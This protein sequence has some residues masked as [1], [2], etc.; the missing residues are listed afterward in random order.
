MSVKE[1]LEKI[2]TA[3]DNVATPPDIVIEG[4]ELAQMK[5]ADGETVI[6]AESFEAGQPVVVVS[7]SGNVPLPVGD[8]VLEDGMILV[9]AEEGV[10]AEIKEAEVEEEVEAETEFVTTETFNAFKAEIEGLLTNMGKDPTRTTTTKVVESLEKEVA[11]LAKEKDEL[12]EE[13]DTT[14]D[15][16]T[17]TAAPIE[18]KVV[19]A[20]TARGRIAQ[21]LQNTLN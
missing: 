13:I 18:K 2:K 9:V 15:A 17:I 3:L 20:K 4:L 8:Y 12:Q 16:P 11:E 19:L 14:A 5:L 7:E 21:K 6:E 10:I 1:V